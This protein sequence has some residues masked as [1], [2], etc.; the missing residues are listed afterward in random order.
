MMEIKSNQNNIV[1]KSIIGG[2]D[3][4]IDTYFGLKDIGKPP[5]YDRKKNY[6]RLSKNP[7]DEL[8]FSELIT[9]LYN[10]ILNNRELSIDSYGKLPSRENWRFEKKLEID[11]LNTSPEVTLER[12]LVNA[13]D[14]SLVNQVPTSS[15]L[16]GPR[17]DKVRNIDLILRLNEDEFEFIELKVASN[18]PLYAAMEILRYGL[19]YIYTREHMLELNYNNEKILLA[20]N[21]IHLTVLAPYSYYPYDIQWIEKKMNEGLKQFIK[22]EISIDLKMHFSFQSFPK[23]FQWP[24]VNIE[25][26]N[27]EL[28]HAMNNRFP[29]YQ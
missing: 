17:Q 15:G 22:A 8:I 21:T 11:S 27:A 4:I 25:I 28:I 29:I 6:I 13:F 24:I 18:N 20:A 2:F 19:L 23:N 5:H 10:Q 26:N 7:K 1:I 12:V 9:I 16:V 14:E 3:E